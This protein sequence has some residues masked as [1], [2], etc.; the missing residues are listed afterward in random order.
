MGIQNKKQRERF[1]HLRQSL[2]R[3]AQEVN[4]L[5]KPFFSDQGVVRGS[6]YELK[7][8]CGKP[9]CP[10][11]K[12]QLHRLMV[13]SAS[14]K[15]RTKLAVIPRGFLV[16]VQR[17]VERYRR[18]RRSRSRL[19]EVHKN[20]LTVMDEMEVMRREEMKHKRREHGSGP[21]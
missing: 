13:V 8:K 5:I 17:K 19:L 3:L 9:G 7:R 2:D 10:C 20:I 16:E 21:V 18:L 12:G 6:V 11:T 14:E 15:G 4:D 1:S